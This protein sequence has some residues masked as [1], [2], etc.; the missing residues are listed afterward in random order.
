M[1]LLASVS[2]TTFQTPQHNA[3]GR[4]ITSVCHTEGVLN[5]CGKDYRDIHY[6]LLPQ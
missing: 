3:K 1:V 5:E 6:E 4:G 2:P